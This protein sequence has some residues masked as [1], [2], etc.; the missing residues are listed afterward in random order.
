MRSRLIFLVAVSASCG[1]TMWIIGSAA[2]AW[3]GDQHAPWIVGRAAGI[4]SYLLLVALVMTGLILAHPWRTHFR[5]PSAAMRIRIHVS[6]AAFIL[7]FT[8]LHVCV[9]ATD[10]Y[11][12]VG[13]VGAVLPM[14]S[15]YRPVAVT[16]GVIGIYSGIAAGLTGILASRITGRIWWPLHKFAVVS[17]ALV[18]AH[19]I[20]AG[21]DSVALMVLYVSTGVAVIALAVSRYLAQTPSDLAAE[22]VREYS[23]AAG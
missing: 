5:L 16:L 15:D 6:L 1:I 12:K 3:W 21:R 17:L 7:A 22:R 13:L 2:A 4:T 18:W 8:A 11:A 9:L 14:A 23:N 20:L 19:S 10:K